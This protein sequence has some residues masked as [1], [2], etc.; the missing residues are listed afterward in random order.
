M[1]REAI[2]KA[3][4]S[5]YVIR[6]CDTEPPSRVCVL[7]VLDVYD[8]CYKEAECRIV[9]EERMCKMQKQCL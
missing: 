6:I 9:R 4:I 5:M 8:I 2:Y 7:E 3:R 1:S